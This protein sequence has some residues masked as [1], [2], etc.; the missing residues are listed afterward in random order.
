MYLFD[1][2]NKL[3]YSTRKARLK[4]DSEFRKFTNGWNA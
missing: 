1:E 2:H 3:D 4:L